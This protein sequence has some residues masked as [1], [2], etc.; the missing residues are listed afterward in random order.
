MKFDVIIGNPPYQLS[1]G[2]GTGDSAKPI[3]NLF[4]NQAKKMNPRY[5]SMI[6]PSRWMK[7]G[8]G[9]NDFRE[10][11][12]SDLSLKEIFDF[13]DA[14]EIFPGIH[15]DGGVCYFLWSRDYSGKVSYKYH[16]LDG[17]INK[18]SRYLKTDISETIIRDP[19]QI[20]I[21]EKAGS[22]KE[23]RF[24]EI[25]SPR[26]PFG[27]NSD[28]FN[29]PGNYKSIDVFSAN[30]EGL[31][32]IHG[33]KGKKGGAKRVSG[34]IKPN[35]VLKELDSVNKFKLFFSKAFM[36]TSTVPPEL[37]LGYPGMICTETFLKI[38]DFS[39]EE[40]M[41]NCLKYIKTK[42]FRALLFFNRHSLNISRSTFNYI[43]MQDFKKEITDVELYKKY[44][45]TQVEIDFIEKIILPMD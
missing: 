6:I 42:F 43:P 41:L 23:K 31:I 2:G 13:E 30:K 16:S 9:L 11:M 29:R 7:G 19:R 12:M 45:L 44:N 3:Y 4:I 22:F 1:D 28:F 5:L 14:S 17:N 32:E 20:S 37:I 8:K 15:L 36:T 27:F 18:S 40:E 21:I 39:S 26:N 34:Y 38:G 25:V 24:D 10:D 33:V 35:H